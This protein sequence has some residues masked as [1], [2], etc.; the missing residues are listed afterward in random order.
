MNSNQHYLGPYQ[1]QQRLGGSGPEEIWKALDEQRQRVVAISILHANPQEASELIPRFLYETKN[2]Q[3]L[4]HPNIAQIVDVQVSS[5]ISVPQV[6]GN[7]AYIVTEY[8]EGPSLAE[9]IAATSHIGNFPTIANLYQVLAPIASALDYAHQ[10]GVIHGHV[11]PTAIKFDT[12]HASENLP[13][14]LRL[15]NFGMHSMQPPMTL[16]LYDACYISPELAQGHT[17]NTRSDL[18]SLGVILYELCTGTLP[19]QGDT[20]ADVMM[21]QIHAT[22]MS[23]ASIN[24][25][26]LPGLTAIILRCLA[27]EPA[28]RFPTL[29]AMV[30]ALDRVRKSPASLSLGLSNPGFTSTGPQQIPSLPLPGVNN[31]GSNPGRT[32]QFP[33]YGATSTVPTVSQYDQHNQHNQ[34]SSAFAPVQD[35]TSDASPTFLTPAR[36]NVPST[37][38]SARM[39]STPPATSPPTKSAAYAP[40]APSVAVHPPSPRRRRL[41]PLVLTVALVL[42]LIISGLVALLLHPFDNGAASGKPVFGHTFFTSSGL[43]NQNGS[44]GIADGVQIE[45]QNLPAPFAGKGYYAWMIADTDATSDASPLGLGS[46]VVRDG[47]VSKTFV[48]PQNNDLLS[49]Y[50]RFLVTEEDASTPPTNPSLDTANWRYAAVFSRIPNLDDVVHHYSVLDHLR[51]LL[52]QDPT[53]KSVGLQGGLDIWLFR[54]TLKILEWSGSA[55][56]A[57]KTGDTDLIRRQ[58]V[59]IL[60]Y[61]DGTQFVTTENIPPDLSPILVDPVFGRVGMF[62]IS[63]NQTPPGYLKHIGNHLREVALSAHVTPL[64]RQTANKMNVAINNVQGWLNGVHAAANQLVHMTPDQLRQPQTFSLLNSMFGLAT[65]AFVGQTDPNTNEVKE[66][67]SQIH[68]ESQ[69]LATLDVQGCTADNVKNFCA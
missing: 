31:P 50:S 67:V 61:L 59:R 47:K 51:H 1:L 24:P 44:N 42:L 6:A 16:P 43:L 9:Y 55:R 34:P 18:Y 28:N 53:L 8:V 38:S 3:M 68:Y 21:Q 12:R 57:Y 54:N 64:Q 39:T 26:I 4:R 35:L 2:L 23:P 13:G 63:A 66:G 19:F 10:N 62:Q 32:P 30:A 20:V 27:K 58:S 5:S 37:F 14:E 22:P 17:E 56:D 45:L 7:D 60:D 49:R 29:S 33:T 41:L 48:D 25:R 69:S 11:K 52:A 36:N 65:D 15:V 46:L 40:G